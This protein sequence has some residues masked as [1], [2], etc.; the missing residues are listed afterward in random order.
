MNDLPPDD[1][2]P[3]EDARTSRAATLRDVARLAG[4]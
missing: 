4:V 3:S 2:P 1:A